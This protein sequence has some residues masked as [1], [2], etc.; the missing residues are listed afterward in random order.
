[1]IVPA[2]EPVKL[3][4][5]VE[6][7]PPPESTQLAVV[8]ETPAPLAVTLKVPVGVTA[9]GA[10]SVTVTVQALATPT[11]TGLVH[12]TDVEDGRRMRTAAV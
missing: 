9:P 6:L 2:L 5:H 11:F 10:V 8:G 12:E 7:L 3:T 4:L 1:L